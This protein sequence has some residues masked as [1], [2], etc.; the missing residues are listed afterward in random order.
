MHGIFEFAHVAGPVDAPAA[1]RVLRSGRAGM[2][3]AAAYFSTKYWASAMMSA[4]RSRNGGM[5]KFTTLSRKYRSSRKRV[6]T[7]SARSRLEVA[8]RR[9]SIFT[10]VVPPTRSISRS[11]MAR[12]SLAC[13][14]RSI[15]EI[16]SSSSV[17]PLASSNLPMRRAT[18]PV[19]A[20]FS[21][22]NNSDSSSF[23]GIAAQLTEISGFLARFVVRGRSAPSPPCR[24]RIRR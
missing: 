1:P 6:G 24:C 15:S 22:P 18:A 21:W 2:P 16:S 17:P 3:L 8:I 12:K 19:N 20:P 9:M 5:F 23:S 7:A 4:G 11:W 10:G 13:S 14:R